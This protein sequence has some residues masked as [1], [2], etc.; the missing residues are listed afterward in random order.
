MSRLPVTGNEFGCGAIGGSGDTL[1]L[2]GD[3]KAVRGHLCN[4]LKHEYRVIWAG[5]GEEGIAKAKE[6]IPDLIVCDAVMPGVDG[7]QLCCH[8]KQERDTGHIPIIL[9]ARETSED[10]ILK[11][12][13]A[14]GDDTVTIPVR[15]KLL[16]ARIRNLIGQRRRMFNKLN[17]PVATEPT[18]VKMNSMDKAFMK[19]LLALVEK[20]ISSPGL[21]IDGLSDKL[22]MSRASLYRNIN[23]ITGESPANFIRSFRLTRAAQLLNNG[24]GNVTEVALHVGVSNVSYFTKIFKKKFGKIPSRF[25]EAEI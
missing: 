14:G 22:F 5:E 17:P 15:R 16:L 23:R 13:E 6:T 4:V 2:V 24:F 18:A 11:G 21:N 7:Y 25:M 10:C 19:E 20:N 8:L 9:L 3:N 1:L 12:L